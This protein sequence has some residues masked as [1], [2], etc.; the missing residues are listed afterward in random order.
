MFTIQLPSLSTCRKQ[1]GGLCCY[2]DGYVLTCVCVSM[3]SIFST[4]AVWYRCKALTRAL[5]QDPV[6]PS[7]QKLAR[8]FND[9]TQSPACTLDKEM[10]DVECICSQLLFV[11]I[12]IS[13]V[14]LVMIV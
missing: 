12:R 6:I 11:P 9:P 8:Q 4:M 1:F 2:C 3:P 10:I 13:C 14:R 7:R 5:E